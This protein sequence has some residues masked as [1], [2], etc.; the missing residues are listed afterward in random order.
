MS[1][2]ARLEVVIG[3]RYGLFPD[4]GGGMH[5][6]HSVLSGLIGMPFRIGP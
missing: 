6:R 5:D 1:F 3:T 4:L 2:F